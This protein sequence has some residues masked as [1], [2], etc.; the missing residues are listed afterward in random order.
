M[1][2]FLGGGLFQYVGSKF[3]KASAKREGQKIAEHCVPII[4]KF[5]EK[6][7]KAGLNTDE[8]V[9]N[10]VKH[11]NA[12]LILKILNSSETD[13]Q[14]K[15]LV[16]KG[17]PILDVIQESGLGFCFLFVEATPE[18]ITYKE[19]IPNSNTYIQLYRE[20]TLILKDDNQGE[21]NTVAETRS[22]LIH[23]EINFIKD[24]KEAYIK[25]VDDELNRKAL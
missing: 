16:E 15:K 24:F 20:K 18:H 4:E 10:G 8:V 25:Y 14:I 11:N 12:D 22:G 6:V 1:G 5:G 23:I 9:Q 7:E 19:N 13:Y 21:L 17:I 3:V 2:G